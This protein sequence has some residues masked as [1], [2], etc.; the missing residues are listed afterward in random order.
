MQQHALVLGQQHAL[1][2]GQ[3]HALGRG[4]GLGLSSSS[5]SSSQGGARQRRALNG[6]QVRT[7]R[8][9]CSTLHTHNS[10]RLSQASRSIR[11]SKTRPKPVAPPPSLK[12]PPRPRPRLRGPAACRSCSNHHVVRKLMTTYL[13]SL[14]TLLPAWTKENAVGKIARR[15]QTGEIVS[16][17]CR[18]TV[19]P[20]TATVLR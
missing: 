10:R 5:S 20:P 12:P 7:W 8:S 18:K 14:T 9:L 4:L 11:L 19:S 16:P 2:L 1:V 13:S 15:P 17:C 3:Q 6:K